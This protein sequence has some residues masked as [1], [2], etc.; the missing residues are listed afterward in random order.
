MSTML[1]VGA[2]LGYGGTTFSLDNGGGRAEVDHTQFAFYGNYALGAAYL[3]GMIGA[4]YGDGTTRRNVSLPGASAQASGHATDT[5]VLGS[6]EAGYALPTGVATFSPF[7]GLTVQSIDQ[8]GFTETGAGVLG[9]RV[10]EQSQSSVRS[11][12]GTRVG[13]DVP[14]G[15]LVI[16]NDLSVAWAH[17]FAPVDRGVVAAFVGAP[18]ASFQVMGAK[19]PGDSAQVGFGLATAIFAGTNLYLH[20][21]G[22]LASGASSHAVTAGFGLRW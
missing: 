10:N 7:A 3:D 17:E 14:I 4:A 16:S 2:A 9:L 1:R 12:L 19:V 11:T 22:D 6:V 15:D 13:F 18:G 21:D 8:D 5:Q 20:Y